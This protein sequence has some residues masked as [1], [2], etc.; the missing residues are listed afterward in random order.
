MGFRGGFQVFSYAEVEPV[1]SSPHQP[2]GVYLAA[3]AVPSACMGGDTLIFQSTGPQ[4][5]ALRAL[6]RAGVPAFKPGVIDPAGALLPL[7]W[8]SDAALVG[9][10]NASGATSASRTALRAA[11]VQASVGESERSTLMQRTLIRTLFA[12]MFGA[13]ISD[14]GLSALIDYASWGGTCVLGADFH[15][16][17]MGLPARKVAALRAR[18]QAAVAA[19]PVGQRIAAEARASADAGTIAKPA[20]ADAGGEDAGAAIIRQLADGTAFAGACVHVRVK[21]RNAS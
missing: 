2:R 13:P 9:G 11:L 16:L 10:G 1:L 12:S 14:D 18:I 6:L 20:G 21:A 3:A 8:G 17:T 5:S 15:A 19:T 7:E 4:H